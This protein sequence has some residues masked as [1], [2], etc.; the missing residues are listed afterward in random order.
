MFYFGEN[1]VEYDLDKFSRTQLLIGEENLNK[2]KLSHVAVF[3]LGGVGSYVVE[4]L[5]RCGVGKL[6]L[7]DHDTVS[8]S[9]VNRQLI[10]LHS[11][12]GK[13]KTDVARERVLDINPDCEVTVF[14]EFY[15][16]ENADKI[17]GNG[18][19]YVVD[20]I[21]SVESKLDLIVRCKEN[22]VPIISSMGTGNKL[23]PR[24]FEVD[25]IYKTQVCPLCRSMR[26]RLKKL[27]VTQLKV[28]YSREM[29][30]QHSK[31]LDPL[32]SKPVISSIS[33]VPSVAGLI[34]A[35]NVIKDIIK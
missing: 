15:C 13:K 9:N 24:M 33:F 19:D 3:G 12:L 2:I 8:L 27:G 23:N 4:A 1:G 16:A 6:T 18:F 34:I 7:V 17:F 28:V 32:S 10:A 26:G 20:A 22:N 21:D 5:A 11:T 25:D 29:P 14:D 31:E 35:E 30:N